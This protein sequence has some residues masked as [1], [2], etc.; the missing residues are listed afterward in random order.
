MGLTRM[1]S[2]P[3]SMPSPMAQA[4]AGA[5]SGQMSP[6]TSGQMPGGMSGQ[7][8]GGIS[9]HMPLPMPLLQYGLGYMPLPFATF[10]NH[11]SDEARVNPYVAGAR[12][13]TNGQ[14]VSHA[15]ALALL[16]GMGL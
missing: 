10:G 9:G 1:M 2:G 7:M 6:G 3:S 14:Y 13:S 5:L 11:F 8:P 12:Q 15:A 16:L 4:L